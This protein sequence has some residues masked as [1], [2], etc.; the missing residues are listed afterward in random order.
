MPDIF[1]NDKDKYYYS[2]LEPEEAKHYLNKLDEYMK[3]KRPYTDSMISLK[4]V[5]SETGIPERHLSQVINEYKK[6]NFYDFI[7]FYR[8]EEVKQLLK[9]PEN[10]KRT[11][12]DILFEAGFNSKTSFNAA[13][14]KYTGTTPSEF[15]KNTSLGFQ[16]SL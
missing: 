11:L 16:Y 4:K 15:R 7:N 9:D 5:S 12:F 6:Q 14:K 8:V 13:F 10:I 1:Y 2:N 3:K